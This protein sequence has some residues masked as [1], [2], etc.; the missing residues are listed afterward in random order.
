M[1]IL[2]VMNSHFAYS[3]CTHPQMVA[4]GRDCT[5]L[6]PAVVKNVVSKSPEVSASFLHPFIL[7]FMG[8]WLIRLF[9]IL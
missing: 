2:D 7:H 6:F 4:K 3:I 9:H 1:N 5:N 8:V